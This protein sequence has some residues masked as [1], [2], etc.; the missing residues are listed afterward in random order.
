MHRT[1]SAGSR[2]TQALQVEPPLC[3]TEKAS[4]AVIAALDDMLWN[5][6]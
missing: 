5:A 6:G 3:V 1:P 2:F 4:A